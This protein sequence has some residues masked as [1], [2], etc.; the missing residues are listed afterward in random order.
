MIVPLL[1]LIG[2]LLYEKEYKPKIKKNYVISTHN[3][4]TSYKIEYKYNFE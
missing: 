4:K 2:W 1:L 3:G